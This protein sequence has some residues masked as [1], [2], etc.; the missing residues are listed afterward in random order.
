MRIINHLYLNT[1]SLHSFIKDQ[2]IPDNDYVIIQ[3]FSSNATDK[4]LLKVRKE[5]NELLPKCVLIGSTTAGIIKDGEIVDSTINISFSIFEHSTVKSKC[6]CH[7]ETDEITEQLSK[8]LITPRT[9]LLIFFANTF[10][11]DS[12]K[13]LKQIEKK[14]PSLIIAGGNGADDYRFEGCTVFSNICEKCDAVFAAID[15]DIL[16]VQTSSLLKWQSIGKEH[17]VTK[18]DGTRLYELCNKPILEVY[19]HYFGKEVVEQILQLGTKFPLI[20]TYNGIDVAR[21]PVAVHEDGSLTLAGKLEEGMKVRFGFANVYDIEEYNNHELLKKYPHKME[22]VYIYS[23]SARRAMIGEYLNKEI[24]VIN[25]IAPTSGFITYGEFFHDIKS[26]NNSLLNITTTFV[27]LSEKSSNE[28]IVQDNLSTVKN[29][30]DITLKAL[31]TFLSKTSN[32]LEE[33]LFYLEQFKKAIDEVTLFSLTD[34]KGIIKEANKNFKRISGYTKEELIGK[35]HNIVRHPDMPQ[36]TFKEMWK[37]IQSGKIW[38]GVIKNRRKDGK[39]YYVLTEISPIYN[40]DGSF[41]EYMAVRNDIT[42][43]EEYKEILKKELNTTKHSLEDQIYYIK[44]YEEAVNSTVAILKTDVNNTI[45][46]ANQTFLNLMKYDLSELI[47]RDCVEIRHKKHMEQ[48]F[49]EKIRE[50]LEKKEN[51][52]ETITN[53]AKNGSEITFKT[54]LYPISDLNGDIIEHLQVMHDITEIINLNEEITNTQREVV[55]TMGA[56]GETRSKETGLHVQRVAEYSY[57][58]A[59]LAGMNEDEALLLKQA[60]PMHDIG[61]VGIPDSILNKPGKLTK[62]EFEIMKTHTSLGYD[63]LKHSNRDILKASSIVALEHHEK[64][65][66]SGYP[67]GLKGEDIH[68]Y[69]RIT[70]IADVF[71]ALGHDRVYKKAWKL[72][73][74]LELFKN[75]RGIHFDPKLIDIFFENLDKFLEIKK[76]YK[77]EF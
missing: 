4:E 72:D 32:E 41:K 1:Q 7:L 21:A 19:E 37:T 73:R 5:L 75:E 16:D 2:Q 71:D 68:I 34:E 18:V 74:I 11:L 45:T 54:T 40:K 23:C 62:E 51:I 65:N 12:E 66:G 9:K 22:A 63:M 14:Y 50:R 46:Y 27:M 39:P 36:E 10:T 30:Q 53:I 25:N 31:T 49:C 47:G 67:H 33:N 64:W 17:I 44:Q 69:G 13:L 24:A 61:K 6:Y 8:E 55:L 48:K 77:S 70:A 59:K 57:L 20:H 15:S 60:S 26:E 38:K 28:P 56:I 43:L 58:L 42:E 3:A 52:T 29:E 76:M 35:P